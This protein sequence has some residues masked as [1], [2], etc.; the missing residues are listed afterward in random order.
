[1]CQVFS[2]I[3]KKII[4]NSSFAKKVHEIAGYNKKNSL[5]IFN[6]VKKNKIIQIKNQK[7]YFWYGV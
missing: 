4:Y 5:V 1:M 7:K 6:G 2:I 3:P